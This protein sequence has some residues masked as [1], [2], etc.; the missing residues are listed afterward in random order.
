MDVRF[1]LKSQVDGLTESRIWAF[2]TEPEHSLGTDF[3]DGLKRPSVGRF[4]GSLADSSSDQGGKA[5]DL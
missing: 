1:S 5:L 4:F 2:E 3:S